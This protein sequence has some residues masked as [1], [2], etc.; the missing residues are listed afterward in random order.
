MPCNS[1]AACMMQDCGECKFCLDKRKFGGPGKLKKRC[2]LRTCA[3]PSSKVPG[4]SKIKSSNHRNVTKTI[5]VKQPEIRNKFL[6]SVDLD[7][8][9]DIN[10]SFED[11]F[12]GGR[13]VSDDSP[14]PPDAG[15]LQNFIYN[16]LVGTEN[17]ETYEVVEV[18]QADDK[19]CYICKS[20]TNE[21][22]FY[23]S[24]CYDPY[25]Q[26]CL[27]MQHLPQNKSLSGSG[28]MCG[29]CINKNT[30]SYEMDMNKRAK[31]I[32][33]KCEEINGKQYQVISFVSEPDDDKLAQDLNLD[34]MDPWG[35]PSIPSFGLQS[36]NDLP[37]SYDVDFDKYLQT[38]GL[39]ISLQE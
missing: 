11:S 31:S 3:I 25:H 18:I 34:T 20:F 17:G 9:G 6:S 16:G 21:D 28:S 27:Q 7:D 10:T 37:G 39:A 12:I 38:N 30:D 4:E 5:T 29:R 14:S 32:D 15:S 35:L 8:V 1:C 33:A 2:E 24:S 22:L 23:C 19:P 36:L 26:F 13:N